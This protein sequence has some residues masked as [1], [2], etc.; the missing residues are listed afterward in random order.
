M[1]N[2]LVERCNGN[3]YPVAGFKFLRDRT[4]GIDRVH[5]AVIVGTMIVG[6][7]HI[8]SCQTGNGSAGNGPVYDAGT[9]PVENDS[10]R[11]DLPNT[12]SITCSFAAG[13]EDRTIKEDQSGNFKESDHEEKEDRQ[14][15]G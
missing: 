12:R 10:T 8:I 11:A 7:F 14:G 4:N 9:I 1:D 3:Y 2:R 13:S 6:D 5:G 15:H